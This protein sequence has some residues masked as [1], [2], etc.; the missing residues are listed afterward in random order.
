M[1]LREK[2][3][4]HKRSF[5]FKCTVKCMKYVNTTNKICLGTEKFIAKDLWNF[6]SG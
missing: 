1:A 6:H 2:K 5:F 3:L 4:F